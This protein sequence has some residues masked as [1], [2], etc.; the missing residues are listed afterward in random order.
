[1]CFWLSYLFSSSPFLT[2][3]SLCI[4]CLLSSSSFSPASWFSV[5]SCFSSPSSSLHLAP[6]PPMSVSHLLSYKW[7]TMPRC[8]TIKWRSTLEKRT[9]ELLTSSPVSS[10][11]S[12]QGLRLCY[13]AQQK[14]W[15]MTWSM[16]M[17]G[18]Y[19]SEAASCETP[20]Y[21]TLFV[22][23]CACMCVCV[24]AS[25]VFSSKRKHRRI[26]LLNQCFQGYFVEALRLC[27]CSFLFFFH[28]VPFPLFPSLPCPL[29]FPAV[30]F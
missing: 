28:S 3:I 25:V 5:L 27:W 23:V 26:R 6:P 30:L 19:A 18:E 12:V 9:T 11:N 14:Y 29:L 10:W 15:C 4:Y 13:F 8:T 22:C 17:Q 1:M 20:V 7:L 21:A 16:M 2:S 24:C